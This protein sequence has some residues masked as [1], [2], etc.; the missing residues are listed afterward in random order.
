MQGNVKTI[1]AT[2]FDGFQKGPTLH[3]CFETF[4]G[5]GIFNSDGET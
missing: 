4:L 3:Q 2:N 5:D 1:L